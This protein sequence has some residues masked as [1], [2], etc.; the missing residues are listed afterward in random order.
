MILRLTLGSILFVNTYT[1]TE[2]LFRQPSGDRANGNSPIRQ[3]HRRAVIIEGVRE[4]PGIPRDTQTAEPIPC[5][6][7]FLIRTP[8]EYI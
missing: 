7:D 2:G 3:L 4:V 5:L 8:A 1:V 6:H